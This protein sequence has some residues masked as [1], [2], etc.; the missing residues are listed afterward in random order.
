MG[1]IERVHHLDCCTMCPVLASKGGHHMVAHV[2]AIETASSGIVLVDTGIGDAARKDLKGW[3]GGPFVKIVRPD[4]D[5]SRSARS[6]LVALGLDP[7]DVRHILLTHLDLD[8]AGALADFPQATVH[9]HTSELDAAL[10]PTARERERYRAIQWAHGPNWATYGKA[11]ETWFGFEAVH[12]L[13]GLPNEILAIPLWGHTRGHA[14]IAV[15][16]PNGWLLHAGDAYFDAHTVDPAQPKGPGIVRQFERLVAVDRAQV[17]VNH[18]R[19]AELVAVHGG[20]EGEVSVF[21]AHD[22]RELERLRALA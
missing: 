18:A 16:G 14:A 13:Q 4:A 7:A 3:L 1:E 12:G 19:L 5:P 15:E 20:P 17:A 9:V 10:K 11:G 2:L 21:S 8:H 22:P 6:Q